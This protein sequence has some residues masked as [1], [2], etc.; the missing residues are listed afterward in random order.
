MKPGYYK[1]FGSMRGRHTLSRK[2]CGP[3]ANV[4]MDRW[5]AVLHPVSGI[6]CAKRLTSLSINS[7]DSFG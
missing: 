5:S 7:L 1:D 3:L 6:G 2:N 4:G